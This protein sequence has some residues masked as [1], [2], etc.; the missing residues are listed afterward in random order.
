MDTL[1]LAPALDAIHRKGAV[2]ERGLR[3]KASTMVAGFTQNGHLLVSKLRG[4]A[5]HYTCTTL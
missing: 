3:K 4:Q 1:G 5:I 2:L